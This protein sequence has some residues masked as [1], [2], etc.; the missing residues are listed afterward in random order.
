MGEAGQAVL[1]L[2]GDTVFFHDVFG[3]D[4]HMVTV[5]NFIQPVMHQQILYR[6]CAGQLHAVAPPGLGKGHGGIAHA[7]L[8][9][10]NDH[11]GLAA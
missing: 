6:T 3:G 4:A 9:A 11:L 8:A 10:G 5:E 1:V 2:P 7:L